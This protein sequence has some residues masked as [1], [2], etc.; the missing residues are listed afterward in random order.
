MMMSFAG[1]IGM[2]MVGSGLDVALETIYGPISVRNM[3]SGKAIAMLIRGNFLVESVL[4]I[5]MLSNLLPSTNGIT[6]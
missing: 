6:G 1:T 2:L 4:V 3:L 5:K